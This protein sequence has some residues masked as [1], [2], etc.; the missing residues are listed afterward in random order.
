MYQLSLKY[1][2]L[3]LGLTLCLLS[4]STPP[5]GSSVRLEPS[6]VTLEPGETQEVSVV[7]YGVED[8]AGIE[9]HI[10]FNAEAVEVVDADPSTEGVQI[11]DGG[12]L[13][14]DFV[15]QNQADNSTGTIDYAVARMAPNETA[16]GDGSLAVITFRAREGGGDAMVELQDVLLANSDGL[17]IEID[18][19]S[20]EAGP[21]A[22]GGGLGCA[23]A[24]AIVVGAVAV[25][26][27]P[28]KRHEAML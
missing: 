5:E 4:C 7:V 9:F 14:A 6:S 21:D 26:F 19:V 8:L 1:V 15:A 12:F 22:A 27:L 17:P 2:V 16:N 23:S 13:S 20:A 28:R 25:A 3:V 11:S 10:V 18:V 24:P